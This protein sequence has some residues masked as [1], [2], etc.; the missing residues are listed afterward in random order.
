[1]VAARTDQTVAAFSV[2]CRQ[3]GLLHMAM[4]GGGGGSNGSSAMANADHVAMLL[5]Y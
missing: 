2:M 4:G 3:C 5:R 1:M